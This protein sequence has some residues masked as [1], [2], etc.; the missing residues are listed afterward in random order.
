MAHT[1]SCPSAA[2]KARARDTR[3]M[4]LC[5]TNITRRRSRRSATT[6]AQREKA[7]MGTTRVRP[8]KPRARADRVS[9]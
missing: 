7:M 8:T 9:R 3:A 4:A 6:P 2:R 5:V 1:A